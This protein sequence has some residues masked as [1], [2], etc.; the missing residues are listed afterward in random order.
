MVTV[1]G[2][3]KWELG[4]GSALRKSRRVPSRKPRRVYWLHFEESDEPGGHGGLAGRAGGVGRVRLAPM[5][6]PSE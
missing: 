1:Y 2:L 4:G 5:L 3:Q 6:A